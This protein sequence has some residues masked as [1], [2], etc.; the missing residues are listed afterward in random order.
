MRL[1]GELLDVERAH[2]ARQSDVQLG[3]R[4]FAQS[5]ELDA[6]EGQLLVEMRHVLLV[7]REAIEGLGHHDIEQ[8]M[9][10]ILEQFDNQA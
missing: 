3:D 2:G 9:S 7:T 5:Y 4:A 1:L 8:A 6:Q 10:R